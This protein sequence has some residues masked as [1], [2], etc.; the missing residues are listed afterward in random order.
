MKI[1]F[2]F[3]VNFMFL[4]SVSEAA[5]FAVAPPEQIITESQEEVNNA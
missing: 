5:D 1:A 2:V 3:M 4:V